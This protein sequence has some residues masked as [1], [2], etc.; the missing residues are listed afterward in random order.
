VKYNELLKQRDELDAQ[1]SEA[2]RA[3]SVEAID[4]VRR[5]IADYAL[6]AKDCGFSDAKPKAM[7]TQSKRGP[8]P[9]KYRGPNGETWSGRGRTPGWLTAIE[10]DGWSRDTCLVTEAA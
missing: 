3:E 4:T 1:I 9:V 6:T 7:V 5:L 10:M 8:A 2:K